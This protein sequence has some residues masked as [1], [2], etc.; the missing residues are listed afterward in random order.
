MYFSSF[1]RFFERIFFT[2]VLLTFAGFAYYFTSGDIS[3]IQLNHQNYRVLLVRLLSRDI[4]ESI[5]QKQNL[6]PRL[7]NVVSI[8]K[9][10]YAI[11]QQPE[12][13]ILAKAENTHFSAG[14]AG[15]VEEKALAVSHL[16]MLPY[17][18]P[19]GV[20]PLVEAVLP[21]VTEQG[22]KLI[23]R[24]GFFSAAESEEIRQILFRNILLGTT[25]FI[26]FTIY[27]FLK[28]RAPWS[29]QIVWM[30][31]I[32]LLILILFLAIR[33]TIQGWYERT[34]NNDFLRQ[35]MSIA[36]I[37]AVNG[38]RFFLNSDED[39]LRTIEN[40]LRSD[41]NLYEVFD[42]L[43]AIKNEK[44]VY[45]SD[46]MYKGK[47]VIDGIFLRSLHSNKPVFK[48]TERNTYD[49]FMPVMHEENR[50]GTIRIGLRRNI[51]TIQF[52]A[53]RK[54]VFLLF[55]AAL[56]I[57][58]FFIHQMAGKIIK[59]LSTLA[60]SIERV[61]AGDFTQP[62]FLER[63]DELEHVSQ[64][65]NFMLMSLKERDLLGK[66]L[67]HYISKSIVNKT[68]KVL[69][70]QEKN[71]EKT[72]SA[73]ISVY[74]SG[75]NEAI[76]EKT[77]PEVFAAIKEI[78]LLLKKACG[79]KVCI[80]T[81]LDG[82]IAVFSHSQRYE[83]LMGALVASKMICQT[84][85]KRDNL[86][87]SPRIS[88]QTFEAVHGCLD[89]ERQI[90]VFLGESPF[91]CRAM[92]QVQD[93]FEIM[94][95]E[96]TGWLIREVTELDEIEFS[97]DSG[98]LRAF[99]FKGFKPIDELSRIFPSSTSWIKTMI[100]KI[101]KNHGDTKIV[102][103]LIAWYPESDENIRYH[104]MDVLEKLHP[105]E[106]LGFVEKVVREESN[107]NVLSKAISTLGRIGNESH[108]A[109]FAEKLRI[110]DRRV[111]ANA[112]EALENIGGKKVY[113]FLNLLVD[114]Q[115][116]RVKANILIALGKYGDL[117]VFDLLSKMIRD[118]DPNMRAS[119]AFALGRLGMAQGV[120]PL[121][122]ALGD[123]DLNVRRQVVASLNALR[124]D[125]DIQ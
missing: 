18:D 57:I 1:K 35:G 78:V 8:E 15:E 117:K 92:A 41:E 6:S 104:I 27:F 25:I 68:L 99:L 23:L 30:G 88:I 64:A 100:L 123:K 19:S 45:H 95:S 77:A 62:V 96:E 90:P 59:D 109:L 32:G 69:S 83:S 11:V 113:E 80:H 50:I 4:V 119:A 81:Q 97:R 79:E 75:L 21:I 87:L 71:G 105:N 43:A 39:E 67:Q 28:R 46:P 34:W 56:A 24:V 108:I 110:N 52:T 98:R 54:R 93:P 124:T 33:F 85:S 60:D 48:L 17:S 47:A 63:H 125:L 22:R 107:L 38:K 84:L 65:Y 37:L 122:S 13:E 103:T 112:V 70:A 82:P 72:F 101:L 49:F 20:I 121:I 91:D 120:D 102:Q 12:G 86:I 26:G 3:E 44:Y 114:E 106:S 14:V 118:H 2:F 66:N 74:F 53:L 116:N 7:T 115:D 5:G 55:T 36:K 73:V 111:K 51:S 42:Y 58:L 76:S 31:G 89:D 61:T 40:I 29:L 9:L 10:A 16:T 94:I